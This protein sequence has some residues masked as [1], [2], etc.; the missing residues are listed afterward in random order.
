MAIGKTLEKK[1]ESTRKVSESLKD[2]A[3][4]IMFES[5]TQK[6]QDTIHK[7]ILM[8]GDNGTGKTSLALFLMTYNLKDDECII[9]IDVDRSGA[10][11]IKDFFEEEEL[12]HQI[13]PFKPI[14]T[15]E[16][17]GATVLDEEGMVNLV[18]SASAAVQQAIDNGIKVKGVIIDGV[19]F[20]L[21]YAEAKMR[22]DKGLDADSGTQLNA[23]KIRSQF[24]R[25]F[26]SAYMGLD[27]PVMFISHEDFIPEGKEKFAEVKKRLISECSMRIVVEKEDS[28]EN[29][30]ITYY[31]MIVK[32]NRSDIFAVGKNVTFMTVN[33]ETQ[34]IENNYEEAYN[35]IFPPNPSKKDKG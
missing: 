7:K 6:K 1:A 22:L 30:H 24:F 32:K 12:N 33:N 16:R 26:T 21:E 35:L 15:I 13:R 34:K 31:N 10:E 19:S 5:D 8:S 20:L 9:H 29:P 11:I 18:T 17:D 4:R 2:E 23:W 25:E 27:V 14:A 28:I 3:Y